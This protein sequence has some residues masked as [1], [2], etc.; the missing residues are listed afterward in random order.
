MV[1]TAQELAEMFAKMPPGEKVWAYW[2]AKDEVEVH[3]SP[4]G[5][6]VSEEDWNFIVEDI[7]DETERLYE[8]FSEAVS[9]SNSSN[10]FNNQLEDSLQRFSQPLTLRKKKLISPKTHLVWYNLSH[11]KA[12]FMAV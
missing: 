7:G 11:P 3:N 8:C 12:R 4:D 10:L 1:K 9:N 6:G 5:K 2:F